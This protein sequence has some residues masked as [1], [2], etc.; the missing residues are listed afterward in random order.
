[1]KQNTSPIRRTAFGILFFLIFVMGAATLI[2]HWRGTPYVTTHIYYSAWFFLLWLALLVCGLTW[3]WK[4]RPL[5]ASLWQRNLH[6]WLLHG[7]LAVILLGAGVSFLTSWSGQVHLRIGETVDKYLSDSKEG[8]E[9]PLPFAVK[10]AN[11]EVSTHAG[12]LVASNYESILLVG[13]REYAVSMNNVPTIGGVRFYQASYDN[14]GGGSVLI[15]RSDPWGQPITYAGYAL[16]LLSLIVLLASPSGGF[17]QAWRC[18]SRGTA[19]CLLLLVATP[20]LYAQER[21][22]FPTVPREV[23]DSFGQLNV[24]YGGRIC[25][26]QTM[27]QDFCRKICG[28]PSWRDYT[29]EQVV[30]GWVFW[31]EDWKRAPMIEVKSRALRTRFDL[32]R[33]ASFYDFFLDGY[34]LG[35]LLSGMEGESMSR[36]AA[37]VDSRIALIYSLTRGELFKFFPARS[38]D[39]KTVWYSPSD[40]KHIKSLKGRDLFIVQS[41]LT[42]MSVSLGVEDYDATKRLIGQIATYQ[43]QK[44][45][46]TLRTAAQTGA[47]RIYNA[48]DLPTWLY[49]INL[50]LGLL[51]FLFTLRPKKWSGVA[52]KIGGAWSIIAFLLLTGYAGLR[53]YIS[54]RLP[55]GNGFETMLAVSWMVM[56]IGMLLW[57]AARTLPVLYSSPLIASGFFLLVASLSQSGAEITELQPVLSSPLLSMHVSIIMFAYALLSFTFLISL[58]ALLRPADAERARLQSLVILYPAIALLAIGIFLG[59]IWANVSWG[60]YWGWD[61]KE[62]WALIT[63]FVYILPLH[64][65]SLPRLRDV[66][67]YHIYLTLAFATVLMT[68]FGVNYVLAGLHSYA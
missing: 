31:T 4:A 43:Q 8:E 41:T 7:A 51:I 21:D 45:G 3:L 5:R 2:E 40:T 27:A 39:G 44:G 24:A 11:F 49:R 50:T 65:G 47:E 1:M 14:D 36:A 20:Q 23:A 18:L 38:E 26:V 35:P 28:H 17:R 61:P 16:L 55:L 25:P 46:E 15:V 64:A 62:V 22:E 19:I 13:G 58:T 30:L 32:S 33:K 53:T 12:T 63:L 60:R 9:R 10:L 54:G 56:L 34:R 68:Y 52:V 37:D 57:R 67:T 66:R 59:A 6:L 29:A 42:D 48:F